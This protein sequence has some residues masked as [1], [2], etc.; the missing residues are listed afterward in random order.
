MDTAKHNKRTED[1]IGRAPVVY[2]YGKIIKSKQDECVDFTFLHINKEA[3]KIIG[4]DSGNIINKKASEVIPG[5]TTT[6][7][8]WVKIFGE[9]AQ[10]NKEKICDMYS[11]VFKKWYQL[12]IHSPEKDYFIAYLSDISKEKLI[13]NI[14]KH[15][16]KHEATPNYKDICD[17]VLYFTNAKYIALNLTEENGKDFRTVAFSGVDNMIKKTADILGFKLIGK[18]WKYDSERAKRIENSTITRFK[19]LADISGN[20][21]SKELV[22]LLQK[23]HKTGELF[24]VKI[25]KDGSILGDF[26]VIMPYGESIKNELL[27]KILAQQMGLFI[28][29]RNTRQKNL[30]SEKK[31]TET[32]NSLNEGFIRADRN[33]IITEVNNAILNIFGYSSATEVIGSHIKEHYAKPEDRDRMISEI[34]TKKILLNY[35]LRHKRKDGS[36]FWTASNI[37]YIEDEKGEI[38]ETIGLVRDITLQKISMQALKESELKNRTILNTIPDLMF[39]NDRNGKYINYHA[40]DKTL[41]A[42][43]PNIFMGK[44]INEV[45]PGKLA[46]QFMTKIEEAL[47]TNKLQIFYYP[48]ET[49]AKPRYFEARIAVMSKNKL[50]TIV[51]DI[52]GQKQIE[53]QASKLA[54]AVEQNPATVMI[55]DVHGNIEYVNKKFTEL[56]GYSKE[57]AL[58]KNPRILKSGNQSESFYKSLWNTIIS[59]NDWH[60]EILNRKKDGSLYWEDAKITSVKDNSNKIINYVAIKEDISY[61]KK[62]EQELRESEEHYRVM[63]E[64][65][66][67]ILWKHNIEID[68]WTYI[69]PQV[70]RILG[71]KPEEF[72]NYEFWLNNIHDDDREW[73]SKYCEECTKKGLNHNFEYRFRKKDGSYAWIYDEVKIIVE[74]EKPVRAWGLMRDITL[75]KQMEETQNKLLQNEKL[76]FLGTLASSITHEVNNSLSGIINCADR[77][78]NNPDNTNNK[79][80][81]ELIQYSSQKLKDY[82]RKLLNFA[83]THEE[84]Y[85]FIQL[86][87]IIEIPLFLAED[88]AEKQNIN[89]DTS[90]FDGKIK[91]KGN[92]NQLEQ[93]LLN[94]IL[95]GID[96]INEKMDNVP[97]S[98]GL[99]TISSFTEDMFTIIKITDNGIGINKKDIKKVYDLFYSKK[100][101]QSGTGLGMSI[102]KNIV[103]KHGGDIEITSQVNEGT[104]VVVKLPTS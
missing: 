90:K 43:D 28:E 94:I 2:I 82:A 42:V 12:S 6:D 67:N 71:Y 66:E 50:L 87:E 85:E 8:E 103:K 24:V 78:S 22:S 40:S 20:I 54:K 95:N 99:I 26:T 46:E 59:G 51:R 30:K 3:E 58:G 4:I 68:R 73:A 52:T 19:S 49:N 27:W 14:S 35:E 39:I 41:L 77:I 75:S 38:L 15:F 65:I 83:K 29:N 72:T 100:Q 76:A 92:K 44:T 102:S 91:I 45:L 89:I 11:H 60:G 55:T 88:Q 61:R 34:K 80:Y 74:N 81:I 32:I 86:S 23:L 13:L 1:L 16:L 84:R 47:K 31:Y 48:L 36:E 69:A 18:K 101:V 62:V 63:A 25:M 70:E 79:K 33:G 98:K 9:T 10:N 97:E 56:T 57:E 53:A 37:R 5:F 93:V 96:A 64:N 21:L 104:E 7:F 17:E